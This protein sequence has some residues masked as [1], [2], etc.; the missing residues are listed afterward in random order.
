MIYLMKFIAASLRL[1]RRLWRRYCLLVLLVLFAGSTNASANLGV[2]NEMPER[3]LLGSALLA[4][5][6]ADGRNELI[7]PQLHSK[8]DI[9]ITGPVARVRVA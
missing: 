4:L 9:H 8:V 2:N 6:F 1:Y 7:A 5:N 3:Q